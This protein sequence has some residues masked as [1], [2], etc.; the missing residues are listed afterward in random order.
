MHSG[1]RNS[2]FARSPEPVNADSTRVRAACAP[3]GTVLRT[4][5]PLTVNHVPGARNTVPN[6]GPAA[7][8]P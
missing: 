2:E 4:E 3:T 8:D 7:Q 1:Q 5:P 6:R